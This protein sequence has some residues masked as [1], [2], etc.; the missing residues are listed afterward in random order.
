MVT[1]GITGVP[2]AADV[3]HGAARV[4]CQAAA[5]KLLLDSRTLPLLLRYSSCTAMELLACL[6]PH[7][8]A[9]A[10]QDKQ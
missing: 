6:D 8:P 7:K 3:A 10:E 4:E 2:L 5:L 9:T 1:L